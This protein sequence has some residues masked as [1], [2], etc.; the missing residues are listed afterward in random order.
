M[1]QEHSRKEL[2]ERKIKNKK[3]KKTKT[4]NKKLQFIMI[5]YQAFQ[6][7]GYILQELHLLLAPENEHTR[8]FPDVAVVEFRNG[9]NL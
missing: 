1:A 9:K 2:F 6:N 3:N 7:V 8:V 4:G 5:Y